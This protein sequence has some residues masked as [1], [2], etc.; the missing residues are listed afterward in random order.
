MDMKYSNY[1]DS[2]PCPPLEPR[3]ELS[4]ALWDTY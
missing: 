1:F 2:A 3:S 4:S